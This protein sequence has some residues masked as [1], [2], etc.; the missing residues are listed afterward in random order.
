MAAYNGGNGHVTDAQALARKYNENPYVWD[1]HVEK[2]IELKSK[3]EYYNDP[4]CKN[5]YLRG[6]EVVRYVRQVTANR[7]KFKTIAVK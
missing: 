2:Y 3:P 5:G 7:D 4:V 6:S 1:G